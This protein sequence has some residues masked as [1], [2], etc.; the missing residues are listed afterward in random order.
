MPS[1]VIDVTDVAMNPGMPG[2]FQSKKSTDNHQ[3]GMVR[4]WDE[5]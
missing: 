5:P 4:A 2:P 3:P 1:F